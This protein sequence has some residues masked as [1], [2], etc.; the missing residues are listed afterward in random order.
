MITGMGHLLGYARVSTGL[1]DP[2][3]QMDALNA[4]GCARVFTDQ[5]SGALAAR[6]QLDKLVETLL[7]GDTLVVWKLDRLG[8]SLQHLIV[9]IGELADKGVAFR[10]LTEGIDTSTAAGRLML[11][12]FGSFA[13]FERDL[14]IERTTAGLAAARARGRPPGRPTVMT[15]ERTAT[16]RDVLDAGHSVSRISKTLGVSRPSVYRA[17]ELSR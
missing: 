16:A 12:L 4:V 15:P 11:G 6:P 9:A 1:Q 14:I 8:R 17:L 13:Q 10:S 3:L 5:A 7:P 2:A